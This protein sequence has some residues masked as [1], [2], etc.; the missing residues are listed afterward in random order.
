MYAE[1]RIYIAPLVGRVVVPEA[2]V[3]TQ[4][5]DNY[6]FTTAAG[7]AKKTAVKPGT[8]VD[9]LVEIISGLKAGDEVVVEGQDQLSDGK[10]VEIATGSSK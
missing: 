9:G 1:S 8:T 6:V 10:K 4:D 5:E 2:A 3:V 7:V